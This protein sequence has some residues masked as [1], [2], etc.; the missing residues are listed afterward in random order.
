MEPA[1]TAT[2]PMGETA[3][4]LKP[5]TCGLAVQRKRKWVRGFEAAKQINRT[6]NTNCTHK[7][8][9]SSPQPQA[10]ATAVAAAR[11]TQATATC[12]CTGP[13]WRCAYLSR[14][15]RVQGLASCL[16]MDVHHLTGA[17]WDEPLLV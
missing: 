16:R 17:T 2:A 3:G 8:P 11:D 12:M 7:G 1:G 15:V 4:I 13:F 9:G 6:L 10:A 5:G 14:L